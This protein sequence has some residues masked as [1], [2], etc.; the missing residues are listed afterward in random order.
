M[1]Q[2]DRA[3]DRQPQPAAVTGFCTGGIDAVKPPKQKRQRLRRYL[4][5]RVADGQ[6]KN[7]FERIGDI[8]SSQTGGS[9]LEGED[10]GYI[11]TKA[12]AL[13]KLIEQ[14]LK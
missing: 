4:L 5:A 1:Q 7:V 13:A 9:K 8:I 11:K 6:D 3:H 10:Q 14:K 12:E 2:H